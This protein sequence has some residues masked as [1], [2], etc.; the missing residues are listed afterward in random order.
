[1]RAGS[2]AGILVARSHTPGRSERKETAT[3][4]AA[5]STSL[6][7]DAEFLRSYLVAIFCFFSMR[8]L[9]QRLTVCWLAAVYGLVGLTGE[10]LH[11]LVEDLGTR[12]SLSPAASAGYFH[13]HGPD[14]HGHLH[15]NSQATDSAQ[16]GASAHNAEEAG[17]PDGK[18]RPQHNGHE[19][20][21]CPLLA[22]V[23]TLKLGHSATAAVFIASE[24]SSEFYCAPF[25]QWQFHATLCNYA[26]GPP[27]ALPA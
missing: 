18:F 19:P 2:W 4:K 12:G 10:S 13:C 9:L 24:K 7:Y 20:H 22:V 1:M 23:A 15:R 5:H 16:C 27:A 3:P 8:S 21:A 14:Y 11:Y 6:R 17:R 26:R 25:S